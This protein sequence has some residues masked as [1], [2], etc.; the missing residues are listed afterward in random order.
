MER[1][2]VGLG[3]NVGDRRATLV[4]AVRR[5]ASHPDIDVRGC[6]RL[7]E[8]SPVGGPTQADFLNAVV[9]VATS[10]TPAELL[11]ATK[12]LETELGRTR[13][14]HWGPRTLDLDILFFGERILALPALEIPHPR[15]ADRR[16]VLVPLADLAPEHRHPVLGRTVSELLGSLPEDPEG[17]DDVREVADDWVGSPC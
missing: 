9:E 6:S 7:Y 10:L 14:V 8:T 15:L 3:G 1:V 2:Y 4:L 11:S 12:E 5:L 13:E 17:G 16:F